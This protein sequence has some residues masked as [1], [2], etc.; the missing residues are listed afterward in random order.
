MDGTVTATAFAGDGS[1]LTGIPRPVA[2]YSGI[3]EYLD[4]VY[5]DDTVVR[6]VTISVPSS[7]TII[8]NASGTVQFLSEQKDL[9]QASITTG[10]TIDYNGLTVSSD[11]G[12]IDTSNIVSG[13]ALTRGYSVSAGT[14]TYNLVLYLWSG[15]AKISYR[16]INA[17]F[18]PD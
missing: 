6:S 9:I 7:G 11:F 13:Y 2:A 16:S 1:G 15:S 12:C 14:Y 4:L 17:I 3:H 10:T 8:V 5:H 18:I